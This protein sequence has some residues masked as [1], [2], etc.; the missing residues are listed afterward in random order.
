MKIS[1]IFDWIFQKFLVEL[2]RNAV[3]RRHGRPVDREDENEMVVAADE[4]VLAREIVDRE[5]IGD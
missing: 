1:R 5:A 2:D 3:D 4:E